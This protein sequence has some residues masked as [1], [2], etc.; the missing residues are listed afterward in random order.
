MS[1]PDALQRCLAA[2]HAAVY[3]YGVVGGVL[4]GIDRAS[5]LQA[6]ADDCY[7]VHRA[8]RDSLT[9]TLAGLGKT[10]VAAHPAYR[11]PFQV[12]GV[13]GCRSLARAIEHRTA[14]VYAFAVSQTV[15]GTRAM[16]V[17]ALTD[18]AVREVAWGAAPGP[19]PG[20]G[21]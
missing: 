5:K 19:F 12:T 17:D 1:S 6:Y 9:N 20:L 18:C 2:E 7:D 3:G 15:K 16:A 4:A 21:T 13:A 10:P 11:L 8:R 14:A